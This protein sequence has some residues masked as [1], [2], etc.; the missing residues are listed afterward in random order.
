MNNFPLEIQEIIILFTDKKTKINCLTVSKR[1]NNII[2]NNKKFQTYCKNKMNRL[3]LNYRG[4][5]FSFHPINYTRNVYSL[6][7]NKLYSVY[8]ESLPRPY[9]NNTRLPS[10]TKLCNC[11]IVSC[12]HNDWNNYAQVFPIPTN[13]EY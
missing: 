9:P 7:N 5:G 12:Q 2:A 10:L 13:L 1:F 11:H 6:K 8:L 3:N 4:L